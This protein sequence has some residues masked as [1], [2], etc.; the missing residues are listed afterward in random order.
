MCSPSRPTGAKLDQLRASLYR[1]RK[2]FGQVWGVLNEI[3]SGVDQPWRTSR[4]VLWGGRPTTF[5]PERRL[6]DVL[7]QWWSV[8]SATCGATGPESV[9]LGFERRSCPHGSRAGGDRVTTFG[10]KCKSPRQE[11][12]CSRRT[13]GPGRP[14]SRGSSN[15]PRG[16]QRPT[17]HRESTEQNSQMYA[18]ARKLGTRRAT[19]RH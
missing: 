9:C 7:N 18:S 12:G 19:A 1:A 6:R 17:F 14:F 10:L 3:R 16:P 4:H 15:E 5:W 11:A 2:G 8:C 13:P